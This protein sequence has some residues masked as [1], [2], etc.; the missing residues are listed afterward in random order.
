[1]LSVSASVSVPVHLS[2]STAAPPTIRRMMLRENLW[3]FAKK[4][5]ELSQLAADPVFGY[6]HA[7]G[8]PSDHIRL[9]SVHPY[10]GEDSIVKYQLETLVVS[11]TNTRAIIT[12]ADQVWLRY[13]YDVETLASWEADFYDAFAWRLSVEFA[14]NIKKSTQLAQVNMAEYRKAISLAKS[15]GG[16]EAWPESYPSD[17]EG[18]W[19]SEHDAGSTS[20]WNGW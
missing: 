4:R 18:S 13:V 17:F 3:S 1:M 5:V 16:I 9:I 12:N 8:L 7:Y 2:S 14:S 11:L 6:D 19:I 20:S 15:T 10:D